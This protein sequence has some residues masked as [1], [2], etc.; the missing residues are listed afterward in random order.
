MSSQV[1]AKSLGIAGRNGSGLRK[2]AEERGTV[3]WIKIYLAGV[4]KA[5]RRENK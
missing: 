3:K 5:S 1:E 2:N 4:G